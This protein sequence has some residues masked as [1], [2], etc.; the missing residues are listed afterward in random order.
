MLG[1]VV[2]VFSGLV[3]GGRKNVLRIAMAQINST[4][5]DLE[6]NV[7]KIRKYIADTKRCGADLVLF[8]E[9]AVTGYPPQDLLLENGF[10]EKKQKA[11]RTNDQ[12]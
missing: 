2:F 3:R 10:V 6:G 1:N 7:A 11:T 8:P 4:V 12:G 5:G 9:L